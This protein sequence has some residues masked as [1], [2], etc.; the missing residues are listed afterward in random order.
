MSIIGPQTQQALDCIRSLETAR[1]PAPDTVE[2]Q[3]LSQTERAEA[4]VAQLDAILA[5]HRPPKD[6]GDQVADIICA[7][8]GTKVESP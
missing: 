5:A 7:R 6:L 2:P 3:P 8:L 1:T 4:A